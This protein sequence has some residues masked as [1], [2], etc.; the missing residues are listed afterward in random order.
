MT[1][2]AE[3]VT[4]TGQKLP[5]RMSVGEYIPLPYSLAVVFNGQN[6]RVLL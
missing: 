2:P 5:L 4:S 1:E 3:I 6:S